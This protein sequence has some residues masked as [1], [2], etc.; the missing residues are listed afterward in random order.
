MKLLKLI[1]VS[2]F[3]FT[4]ISS[5]DKEDDSY[6]IYI[7]TKC[8]DAW[9]TGESSSDSEVLAAVGDYLINLGIDYED[10]E[11]YFEESYSQDCEAC[12]CTTGRVIRLEVDDDQ[13]DEMEAEGFVLE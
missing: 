10:L 1:L 7:E 5:C 6:M 9:Q 12:I 8:A 2:T 4:T 3:L 13:V 11:I